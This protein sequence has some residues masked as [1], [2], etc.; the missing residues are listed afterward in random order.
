MNGG[1]NDTLAR[2]WAMLRLI[3]RAPRKTTA[4]DLCR[5]LEQ[6]GHPTSPRTVE[7]DLQT[8]SNRFALVADDGSKPYG[9]SWAKDADIELMPRLS[10][11]CTNGLPW[12]PIWFQG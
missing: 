12:L 5:Q 2:Q 6:L 4:R 1:G 8:L 9:W 10:K 7:R 3:P 11:I